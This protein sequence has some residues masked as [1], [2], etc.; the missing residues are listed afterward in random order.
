[1]QIKRDYSEPFF[2]PHGRRKRRSYGRLLFIFG[3]VVGGLLLVVLTQFD[4]LQETVLDMAG[5]SATATPAS[6]ALATEALAQYR[7]GNL[8][9]A[10]ALFQQAISQRPD[11]VDYLY[12]YGQLLIEMDDAQQAS[13]L[14]DKVIE[15]AAADPRGYALKAK[16]LV[17]LSDPAAAISLGAVALTLDANYAPLHAALARAYADSGQYPQALEHGELA[18]NL[19][20]T[21]ADTHR[22]Y[23][24]VLT[25]V[26]LNDQAIDELEQ[27]IAREP[28]LVGPYFEL[29]YQY[30]AQDQNEDAIATYD[31]ILGL[32]PRNAKA[33]L[34]QCLAYSK[35]GQ[36]DRA[37]GFCEDATTN[38]PDYSPAYQQLGI[39]LYNRLD[40]V[41]AKNAFTN[42]VEADPS[43]LEC[44]YRRGLT[45]YYLDECDTAWSILQ[46]SL[47][48]A[49]S[50][51]G[52]QT[53]I[54]NIRQGL[55][56]ITQDCEGFSGRLP[57]TQTPEGETEDG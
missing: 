1:M 45:H 41:A 18:V 7:A 47:L 16:S 34:R 11:S 6:S 56:A 54:D 48:M 29:A 53:A 23:A 4:Q 14:A 28:N 32:Q 13:E 39:I 3:M 51:S 9:E 46:D 49:Q 25:A 38:D 42:C 35:I 33:L 17:W 21:I 26:K 55:T 27:A 5:L 40:F 52:Q 15:L 10:A 8:E 12:E 44:Q 36:F 43:N 31:R 57:M 30:L 50:R 37:I 20:A 2:S 22:S 19:D 24:Y